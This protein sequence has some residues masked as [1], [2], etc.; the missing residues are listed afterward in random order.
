MDAATGQYKKIYQMQS[1][2][3][4]CDK[5]NQLTMYASKCNHHHS[6]DTTYTSVV[7]CIKRMSKNQKL[8]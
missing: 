6:N 7:Y 8:E 3:V 2:C 5:M 4:C 1:M